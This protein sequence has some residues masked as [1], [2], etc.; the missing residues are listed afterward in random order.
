[1]EWVDIHPKL[2]ATLNV[3]SALLL[4][5][6]WFAIRRSQ[7]VKHR[8]CMFGAMAT[9]T[10]FLISYVLRYLH[11]GTHRYA[12]DGLMKVIY[13]GVLFSHM[14]LAMVLVPLVLRTLY[15]ALRGRSEEHKKIAKI[16]LPIWMYVSVNRCSCVFHALLVTSH[17]H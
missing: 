2:N 12:G 16:T 1:M 15:L 7:I 10:L 9:S 8:A 17:I 13:L 4:T 14:V 11:A 5:M 6:G 3:M